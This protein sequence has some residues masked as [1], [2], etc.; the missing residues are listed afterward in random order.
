MFDPY[1][2]EATNYV[3][4]S[5][6]AIQETNQDTLESY[7]MSSFNG[8]PGTQMQ[9]LIPTTMLDSGFEPP[10]TAVTQP[11]RV[12]DDPGYAA[13]EPSPGPAAEQDPEEL[14]HGVASRFPVT[15]KGRSM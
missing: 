2:S 5:N 15:S 11:R 8:P 9:A 13:F 12:S 10:W 1:M 7:P 4:D 14:R 6:P 3:S